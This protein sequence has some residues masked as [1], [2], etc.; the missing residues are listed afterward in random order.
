MRLTIKPI[1]QAVLA[2]LF[3]VI[4]ACGLQVGTV[5]AQTNSTEPTTKQLKL[6]QPRDQVLSPTLPTILPTLPTISPEMLKMYPPCKPG[7]ADRIL[8]NPNPE[9]SK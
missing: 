5:Q 3:A 6:E 2:V 9:K 1:I 4:L 7:D 8:C